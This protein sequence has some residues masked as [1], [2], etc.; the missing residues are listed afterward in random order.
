[1][2]TLTF[3]TQVQY[4]DSQ[5]YNH[6]PMSISESITQTGNGYHSTTQEIGETAEELNLGV[7]ITTEGWLLLINAEASGGAD[8][9]WRFDE[10]AGTAGITSGGVI[11]PGHIAKIQVVPGTEIWM[12]CDPVGTSG[13]ETADVI[14]TL[15]ED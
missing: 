9:L 7:N 10:P 14:A 3:Q 1:M 4:V 12:E 11:E 13:T 5:S 15:F 2:G 6:L 8:L